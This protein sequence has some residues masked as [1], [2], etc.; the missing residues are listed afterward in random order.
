[1]IFAIDPGNA[2]S[3]YVEIDDNFK[4][5]GM[6]KVD[7]YEV[8]SAMT[9]RIGKFRSTIVVIER[10]ASYG[11][12]VGADVFQT[13]EWV[14]RFAQRAEDYGCKVD[15]IYRKEEKL[16]LCGNTAAR[17]NNV[18][19]ALIERF[20]RHDFRSGK[21]TKKKPDVFYGVS[22]DIWSA[23]AVGVTYIDKMKG[24]FKYG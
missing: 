15:Y 20:A 8:L 5:F 1:M 14:G 23:V 16:N 19:A 17:D 6:G 10:V 3:A 2:E 7:N 12:A 24:A 22:N 9:H 4:L 11:M 18:R 21:G 13:C